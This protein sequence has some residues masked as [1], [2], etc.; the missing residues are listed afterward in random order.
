MA[1]LAALL[2]GVPAGVLAAMCVGN[3][4]REETVADAKVPFCSLPEDTR[5]LLAA[6][7]RES[8]SPDVLAV[9]GDT[10]VGG[11]TLS[12]GP[13]P[14][15]KIGDEGTVPLVFAGAG[16]DPSVEI[17]GGTTLDSVAPTIA[18]V[19]GLRRP[20]PGVRSGEPIPGVA[21]GERPRL[22]VE[23]VWKGVTAA[24][25]NR[26]PRRWPVLRG[27][28]EDGA[29]TREAEVG[30]RPLD[31]AAITTTIGTGGLP[32]DHGITGS[33]VAND[34]GRVGTAWG[35][36]SPL[37]VIAGLGDHLDELLNQRPLIGVVMSDTSDL[38]LIGGNW[39]VEHD[40]D[41]RLGSNSSLPADEGR[42]A[43]RLLRTGYGGDDVPDLL[44][45]AM[46]GRIPEMD[47]A[48]G[49]IVSAA[50]EASGGSVLIVAT[51]TGA[52]GPAPHAIPAGELL[53]ELPAGA[54]E[55][56]AQGGLFLDHASLASQRLSD[57]DVVASLRQMRT[58]SGE[59]VFADV[60]PRLAVTFARYC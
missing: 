9:T 31:T 24:D 51:A 53:E 40:D 2:I 47:E 12:V 11:A 16:V 50:T 48:L 54:V 52:S 60:F 30:S 18:E 1:L 45:V 43:S 7:F 23:V 32:R 59:P 28:M 29:L 26:D 10:P 17:P 14:S 22:V 49:T 20:D 19:I 33:S 8:R 37:S 38:G 5:R 3:A 25:L 42:Q 39:Y 35:L 36:A 27:L 6:G 34:D 44:A 56:V 57:D 55:A 58:P 21:S 41:D 46:E 13:W 15:A 4:C